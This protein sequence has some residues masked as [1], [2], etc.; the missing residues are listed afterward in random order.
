MHN[1]NQQHQLLPSDPSQ[2]TFLRCKYSSA[3]LNTND[4]YKRSKPVAVHVTFHVT[5]HVTVH[6]TVHVLRALQYEH[7]VSGNRIGTKDSAYHCVHRQ[8]PPVYRDCAAALP[9]LTTI[10]ILPTSARLPPLTSP[11]RLTSSLPAMSSAPTTAGILLE[12]WAR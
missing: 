9:R 4:F 5:L 11:H 8:L 3:A 12:G 6:V 2:L 1:S 7:S 10:K